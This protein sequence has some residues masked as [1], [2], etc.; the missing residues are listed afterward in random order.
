MTGDLCT[1]GKFLIVRR[2][3]RA[4][5]RAAARRS[6]R[7]GTLLTHKTMPHHGR[8]SCPSTGKRGAHDAARGWAGSQRSLPATVALT[9]LA[10]VP[11]TGL[12]VHERAPDE[13]RRSLEQGCPGDAGRG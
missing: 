7:K 8:I 4:A 11:I 6:A 13:R 3:A 5:P 1:T 2:L 12:P 10:T 9:P